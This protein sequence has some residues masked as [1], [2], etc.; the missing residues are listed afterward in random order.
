MASKSRRWPASR[1]GHRAM[2]RCVRVHEVKK[3][4]PPGLGVAEAEMALE[5]EVRVRVPLS[6]RQRAL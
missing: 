4:V 6:G 1:I 3:I 2:D 5:Q